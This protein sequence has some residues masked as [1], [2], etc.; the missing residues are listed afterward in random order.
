MLLPTTA[1][2]SAS[3]IVGGVASNPIQTMPRKLPGDHPN[4]VGVE[5]ESTSRFVIMEKAGTAGE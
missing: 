2:M 5:L 3:L 1:Y 4:A